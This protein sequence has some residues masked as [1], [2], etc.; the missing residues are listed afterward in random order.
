[1]LDGL[2]IL[3][4]MPALYWI[5]LAAVCALL[6]LAALR[7]VR[8][9][10]SP[11]VFAALLWLA[12]YAAR[13][14]AILYPLPLNPDES[15]MTALALRYSVD[16]VPWRGA[17][18]TT[19]GPLVSYALTPPYL[20]GSR[21]SFAWTRAIGLACLASLLTASFVTLRRVAS[22]TTARAAVVGAVVALGPTSHPD[23]LHC[24]SEHVPL[25]LA[26]V[27]VALLHRAAIGPRARAH[28]LLGGMAAGLLPFAKLQVGPVAVAIAGIAAIAFVRRARRSSTAAT[29]DLV[30]LA[31]GFGAPALAI[32]SLLLATG[33]FRDFWTSYIEW[34]LLYP[35]PPLS[36][37]A[38]IRLTAVDKVFFVWL[39]TSLGV[40][41]LLLAVS[42]RGARSAGAPRI[43]PLALACAAYLAVCVVVTLW[44]GR[45]F[46]HYLLLLVHPTVLALGV[47]GGLFARTAAAAARP[48]VRAALSAPAVAAAAALLV[49]PRLP[50]LVGHVAAAR[51]EGL[52]PVP[53]R[54]RE[55]TS[56]GEQIAIWGWMPS[57]YVLSGLVP[58]TRDAHTAYM[59]QDTR[60]RDY[61]RERFLADLAAS[62]PPLFVDAVVPCAV[63]Y[64]DRAREGHRS[65]PALARFVAENYS[66]VDAAPAEAPP[67]CP[68]PVER[69]PGEPGEPALARALREA[70]PEI[71]VRK[72][73]AAR[74]EA[75][76]AVADPSAPPPD[77]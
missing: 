52:P 63:I 4:R 48:V 42:L 32:F 50:P 31:L 9:A 55:L 74:A 58:A 29:G 66:A 71:F 68:W 75:V 28:A 33:S 61:Y 15:Q 17:D 19:A 30:A 7:P 5:A 59:I 20:F 60:L 35:Q 10:R 56:P 62:R 40:A 8:A 49:A 14:P 13:W 45:M 11:W 24:S 67:P 38:W 70:R 21:P 36:P 37:L 43:P 46:P 1:M 54:L 18:P 2:L 57:Y 72:D 25:F 6:L 69:K 3:D 77:R 16:A 34:G 73:L 22:E 47:A 64:Q 65:F 76:R 12:L 39:W 26:G 53:A 41:A 51:A 23:F 44:P 27:A